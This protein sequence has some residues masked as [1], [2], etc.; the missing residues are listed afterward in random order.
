MDTAWVSETFWRRR[1]RLPNHAGRQVRPVVVAPSNGTSPTQPMLV[2]LGPHVQPHFST[3]SSS[4]S[5]HL[6]PTIRG[7]LRQAVL[8]FVAVFESA[9]RPVAPLLERGPPFFT[10]FRARRLRP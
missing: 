9:H 1:S 10:A 4:S 2:Y 5:Q 6:Q 7:T 3:A 8:R